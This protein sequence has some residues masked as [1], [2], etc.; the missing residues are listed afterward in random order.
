[1]E[2]RSLSLAIELLN[3]EEEMVNFFEERRKTLPKLKSTKLE[4]IDG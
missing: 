2:L 3:E 1:M 4:E